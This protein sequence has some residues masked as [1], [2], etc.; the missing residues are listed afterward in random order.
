MS[1]RLISATKLLAWMESQGASYLVPILEG[2]IKAGEFDPAVQPDIKPRD[3][4]Q[5]K[6]LK[7]RSPG[8][9]LA[10]YGKRARVYFAKT[11]IGQSITGY[12]RL[13]KLEVIPNE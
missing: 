5:H 4:V 3:K 9:V 1:E 10:V 12:Y 11:E 7:K 8:V 13:D 6:D 2:K